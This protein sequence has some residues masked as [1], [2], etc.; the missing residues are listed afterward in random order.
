MNGSTGSTDRRE[1]RL[2]RVS[3]LLFGL[4]SVATLVGPALIFWVGRG[5]E[6]ETY[7]PDRPI[8]WQVFLTVIIL[9]IVLFAVTIYV[10]TLLLR[11]Q[12]RHQR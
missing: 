5:G 3:L 10:S 7:P 9:Y 4:L 11:A 6:R 8:E 1:V 12:K 2:R